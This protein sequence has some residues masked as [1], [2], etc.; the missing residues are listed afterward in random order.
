M[1]SVAW[2][3]LFLVLLTSTAHAGGPPESIVQVAVDPS[4]PNH[5]ALRYEHAGDGV[6]VTTDGGETWRALCTPA[7]KPSDL[8]RLDGL[9]RI[10]LAG[11]GTL[12]IAAFDAGMHDDGTGCGFVQEPM[13]AG[14][15]MK[16]FTTHPSD[17]DVL[18]AVNSTAPMGDN[19]VFM[20]DAAGTWSAVG[21]RD[22]TLIG[23]LLVAELPG[24][25]LRMYQ[26]G[27]RGTIIDTDGVTNWPNFMVR[28]SDDDGATWTEHLYDVGAPFT[29]LT[30]EAVDPTNPDRIVVSIHREGEQG[31]RQGL[32][33][34]VLVSSDQGMTF[35]SYAT[36]TQFG[37]ATMADDG[38]IWI[39]DQGDPADLEQPSGLLYAESLDETPAVVDDSLQVTCLQY[40]PASDQVFACARIE[41]GL[42]AAD[43][44]GYASA[45]HFGTANAMVTCPGQDT[46]ATCKAQF[47]RFWCTAAHFNNAPL[48]C[49]YLDENGEISGAKPESIDCSQYQNPNMPEPGVDAGM[50]PAPTGDGDMT[51]G[52]GDMT[53]TGDG[54]MA[55]T[56]DGDTTTAGPMVPTAQPADDDG[57]GCSV[58]GRRDSEL[59]MLL[60]L[61]LGLFA[62]RLRRRHTG[63]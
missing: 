50:T 44:T 55:T 56:G 61:A 47:T 43:G 3:G 23:R 27:S 20:R 12:F 32:Q 33:D 21:A 11:D 45:F 48:C 62:L 60:P 59:P 36:L 54:D 42:Y 31:G 49:P 53:T 40:L 29:S 13:F 1:R 10:G 38:R 14:Q 9:G 58:P 63:R 6:L 19:G 26:T 8:P 15:W 28:V 7:V 2:L 30:L 25:G 16:D 41:A 35:T 18:Y 24:G 51:T 22:A 57:C 34:E 4:D 17:P 46:V 39:A 37:G 5:I 52:D